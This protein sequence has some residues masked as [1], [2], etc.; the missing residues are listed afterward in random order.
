MVDVSELFKICE[1]GL[2]AVGYELVDLEYVRDGAGW[3]LRVFI[4]H[5]QPPGEEGAGF[6]RSTVTHGDCEQASRQLG[7]VLD[8][9]DVI[10][11]A[12]RLELS[13]PGVKRRVRK[14]RD[15]RRCVGRRVKLEMRVP[16]DGRKAFSGTV[17]RVADGVV[18]VDVDGRLFELELSGLRR[19]ALDEEL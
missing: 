13:S 1:A 10:E 17:K 9:E 19:A 15:F 16:V 8:V 18:A 3:I 6:G 4:D 14:E 7:A 12:Y 11:G 2:A 5:P